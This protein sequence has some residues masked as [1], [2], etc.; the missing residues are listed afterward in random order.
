MTANAACDRYMITGYF[1]AHTTLFDRVNMALAQGIRLIQFRA[2][3]LGQNEYI[4]L[5]QALS[6]TV[7]AA[8]AT[9]IIK[10][11]DSLLGQ[12][13]CHG[14]HLTSH[15]LITNAKAQKHHTGQLLAASCHDAAQIKLAQAMSVDFITLS[16]V[17][18]TPCHRDASSLGLAQ[19]TKLTATTAIPVFWLGG[20]T[21][22][23]IAT[24]QRLGAC[25]IAA[26]REFWCRH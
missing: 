4:S 3:W 10:G 24:A 26:I 5:A 8:D 14:L 2:P 19:A 13:W 11:D 16:P 21:T 22:A 25:G 17:R 12:P 20:M 1:K 6:N 9:L 15:Q 23:D 7:R 18:P